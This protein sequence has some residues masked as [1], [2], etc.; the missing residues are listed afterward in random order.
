MKTDLTPHIAPLLAALILASACG[1]PTPSS[2]AAET[3][4]RPRIST[5]TTLAGAPTPLLGAAL[6]G[7]LALPSGATRA[8]A[9]PGAG[10]LSRWEVS[11]G[12]RVE[13]GQ[14]LATIISQEIVDLRSELTE[15][16]RALKA[17][18]DLVARLQAQVKSGV[19]PIRDVQQAELA[20]LEVR[21]R[22]DRLRRQLAARQTGA[23]GAGGTQRWVATAAGQ[24]T[25]ISCA[26]GAAVDRGTTCLTLIEPRE[27]ELRASLPERMIPSLDQM[28]QARWAPHDGGAQVALKLKRRAAALH[29]ATR[30]L[31][32]FFVREDGA[33]FARPP[34]SSG[35]VE[36]SWP[37]PADAASVPR[38]AVVEIE[39]ASNVFTQSSADAAPQLR[40]V[41]VLGES[42]G[43]LIVRGEGV[44]PGVA[45]VHRGA[46]A[47]K[48][49]RLLAG[50]Q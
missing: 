40:P 5:A 28:S 3:P 38:V 35:R 14:A 16:Q 49:A 20:M 18:Q 15:A 50:G 25:A 47:L 4:Q 19:L 1:D 21:G 24:I 7:V 34:G 45:V 33:P 39:G 31:D 41:K 43:G 22:V 6:P 11:T 46:F 48:S 44:A 26:E 17:H 37:A 10:V 27:A 12:Q 29:A 8:L 32:V 36:L 9:L 13:V 30:T 2:S 23:Q 42:A